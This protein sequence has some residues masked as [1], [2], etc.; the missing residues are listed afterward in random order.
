[1]TKKETLS[2]VSEVGETLINLT[3]KTQ[4]LDLYVM[5]LLRR[6]VVLKDEIKESD[7]K[8]K[9]SNGTTYDCLVFD[10]EER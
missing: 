4:D 9:S 3:S 8:Y 7:D 2:L 5:D 1:M 10:L 6:L